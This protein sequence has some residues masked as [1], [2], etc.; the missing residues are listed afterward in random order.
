MIALTDAA[1]DLDAL[2]RAKQGADVTVSKM[3][4]HA[5]VKSEQLHNAINALTSALDGTYTDEAEAVKM[6]IMKAVK[7][8]NS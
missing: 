2:Y 8:L 3:L 4:A 1:A 7:A 5:D 6:A